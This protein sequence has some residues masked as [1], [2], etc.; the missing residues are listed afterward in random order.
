VTGPRR[1]RKHR[2]LTSTDDVIDRTGPNQA[3]PADTVGTTNGIPTER[4]GAFGGS[5]HRF[6]TR[7]AEHL[8]SGTAINTDG[9]GSSATAPAHFLHGHA[10]RIADIASTVNGRSVSS[11][12]VSPYFT[13]TSTSCRAVM[14][15]GIDVHSSGSS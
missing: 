2:R 1:I 14:P 6:A 15:A 11:G 8:I 13:T 10:T 9:L 7:Y 3:R 4:G 5:A 12:K